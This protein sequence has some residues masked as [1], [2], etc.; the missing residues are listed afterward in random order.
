MGWGKT[1]SISMRADGNAA[2][3]RTEVF[4]NP[5]PERNCYRNLFGYNKVKREKTRKKQR[6][7]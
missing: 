5:S 6:N 1:S 3:I 4:W 7:S 2:E